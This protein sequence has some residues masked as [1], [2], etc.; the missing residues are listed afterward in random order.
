MNCTE[1]TQLLCFK[2]EELKIVILFQFKFSLLRWKSMHKH[3]SRTGWRPDGLREQRRALE[4]GAERR[5]DFAERREHA[6]RAERR[7]RSQ[8]RRRQDVEGGQSSVRQDR[9][10]IGQKDTRHQ[11]LILFTTLRG[12]TVEFYK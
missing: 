10:Q 1:M 5:E 6:G 4:S 3:T 2:L 7:E 8:R 9:R 12:F 11:S